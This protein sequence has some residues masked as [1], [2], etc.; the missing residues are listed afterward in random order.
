MNINEAQENDMTGETLVA[1]LLPEIAEKR[2]EIIRERCKSNA[3]LIAVATVYAMQACTIWEEMSGSDGAAKQFQVWA[4]RLE[5]KP[6][7]QTAYLMAAVAFLVGV[8]VGIGLEDMEGLLEDVGLRIV[9]VYPWGLLPIRNEDT[10]VPAWLY[11]SVNG[12]GS[13][14]SLLT[15]SLSQN[16]VCVCKRSDSA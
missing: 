10:W 16:L 7:I 5:T 15:R 11:L 6:R 2:S 13:R 1:E 12:L 8:I 4:D 9:Q 14:L 3:D